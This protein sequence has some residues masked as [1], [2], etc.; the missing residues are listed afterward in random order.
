MDIKNIY[1]HANWFASYMDDPDGDSDKQGYALVMAQKKKIE[2]LTKALKEINDEVQMANM[3][4]YGE[5]QAIKNIKYII[6]NIKEISVERGN[7]KWI[8]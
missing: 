1:T 3:D 4:R 8:G 7:F 5:K 2:Q 6:D